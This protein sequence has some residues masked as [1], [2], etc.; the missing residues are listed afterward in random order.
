MPDG[1][2]WTVTDPPVDDGLTIPLNG[3]GHGA[4]GDFLFG[5]AA[6]A[7]MGIQ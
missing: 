6:S 4:F 2:A 3:F 7:E 1:D 5:H